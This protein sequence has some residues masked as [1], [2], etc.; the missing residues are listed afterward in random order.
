[1]A[2]GSSSPPLPSGEGDGGG[3][4]GGWEGEARRALAEDLRW[5]AW[6]ESEDADPGRPYE[7]K[8]RARSVL[9]SALEALPPGGEA[10][11][12]R[13]LLLGRLGANLVATEETGTG[14]ERLQEAAA[15]LETVLETSAD[16]PVAEG[17]AGEL[18]L[19]LQHVYNLLGVVW[20]TRN[21]AATALGYLNK[22]E[23][24]YWGFVEG[25]DSGSAA[26]HRRP[27]LT[28]RGGRGSRTVEHPRFSITDESAED[29]AG[30]GLK[31]GQLAGQVVPRAARQYTQTCLYL[32]Q[33]AGEAGHPRTSA[34]YCRETLQ[35]Q[36]ESGD[37]PASTWVDNATK[38]AAYF[39]SIRTWTTA[40][41]CVAAAAMVDLHDAKQKQGGPSGSGRTE[42]ELNASA[43]LQIGTAALY[44]ELLTVGRREKLGEEVGP[45]PQDRDE[46]DPEPSTI[47]GAGFSS[48]VLPR[49]PVALEV[50][51]D[52]AGALPLLKQALVHVYTARERYVVD[53]F[54]T[55]HF[56]TLLLEAQCYKCLAAFEPDTSRRCVLLKKRCSVLEPFG[57]SINPTIYHDIWKTL[58]FEVAET[59]REIAELKAEQDAAE[60]GSKFGEGREGADLSTSQRALARAAKASEWYLRFIAAFEVQGALPDRVGDHDEDLEK[61]YLTGR[62]ALG[63]ALLLVKDP[64]NVQVTLAGLTRAIEHF[65]YLNEYKERNG[66]DMPKGL[67]DDEFSV[68]LEMEALLTAKRERFLHALAS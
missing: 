36:L 25:S 24:T 41:E 3:G 43:D 20:V 2:H 59:Y 6:D 47:S 35:L 66:A 22:A 67:F 23:R 65:R 37:Y 7:G 11:A 46:D 16:P 63:K 30:E 15:L 40:Y 62:F 45:A 32:A 64:A 18:T 13:G 9:E 27:S 8:Y 14:A 33:V 21:E 53:G 54:V 52:Y 19:A 61:W 26:L 1:M 58:T 49:C 4:G 5:T 57:A 51:F 12:V 44:A 28:P 48:L 56:D 42:A 50:P 29:E 31:P 17:D 39:I 10:D 68:C 55:K 38:L 60:S 34:A